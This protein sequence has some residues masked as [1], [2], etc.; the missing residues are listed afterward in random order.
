MPSTTRGHI[1]DGGSD[2]PEVGSSI[3]IHVLTAFESFVLARRRLSL[4]GLQQAETSSR[5]SHRLNP[6]FSLIVIV[7]PSVFVL[8]PIHLVS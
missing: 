3:N 7:H 6:L 5:V 4:F 2:A 8:D 1:Q